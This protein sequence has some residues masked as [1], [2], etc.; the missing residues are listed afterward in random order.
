MS[1]TLHRIPTFV[2]GEGALAQLGTEVASLSG[3]GAPVLLFFKEG[4][5][6]RLVEGLQLTTSAHTHR[7]RRLLVFHPA[8]AA[9]SRRCVIRSG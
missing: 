8:S 5:A 2:D 6:L 9:F 1:T 4:G 3:S 7:E